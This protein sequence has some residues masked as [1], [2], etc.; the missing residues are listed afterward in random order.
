MHEKHLDPLLAGSPH[1]PAG[2]LFYAEIGHGRVKAVKLVI[3][4]RPC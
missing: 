1:H 3:R 4:M 2:G